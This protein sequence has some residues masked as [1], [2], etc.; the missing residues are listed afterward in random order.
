M[1]PKLIVYD[2]HAAGRLKR[3]HVTRQMVRETLALGAYELGDTL[4]GAEQRH[5][6]RRTFRHEGTDRELYEVYL[7]RADEIRV[8]TVA[9][10]DYWRE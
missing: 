4:P 10:S 3:R 8:I 2:P 5:V 1:T 7:E 9:W 6:K